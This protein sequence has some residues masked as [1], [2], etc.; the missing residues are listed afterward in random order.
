MKAIQLSKLGKVKCR[1]SKEVKG[2]ILSATVSQNPSG[3][4]F[5]SLCCTDVEIAPL[6]RMD[7]VCGIDLGIH[8]RAITSDGVKYPNNRYIAQAEKNSLGCNDSSPESQRG[9]TT[10]T[11]R[12]SRLH[13][14]RSISPTSARMRCTR[15][16]RSL[17]G[18]T[19]K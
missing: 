4:Y 17:S 5:V 16:R 7:K 6:K 15:S 9:V 14:C 3:K 10:A 12:G 2:R 19:R 13:D 11:R 8:D 1:I 18:T